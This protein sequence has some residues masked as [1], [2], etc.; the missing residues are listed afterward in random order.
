LSVDSFLKK[1]KALSDLTRLRMFSLLCK[2]DEI[3]SCYF[4]ELFKFAPPTVSRHTSILCEAGL[5]KG[6]KDGRWVYF[7][8]NRN[9]KDIQP[10]LQLLENSLSSKDKALDYKKM[11]NIF[12]KGCRGIKQGEK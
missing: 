8:L 1:A 5:I 9:N 12:D 2:Y 10:W 3:C 7:S 11:K 4:V 6:R